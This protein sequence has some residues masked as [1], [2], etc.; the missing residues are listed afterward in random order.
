[1]LVLLS[2]LRSS[3]FFLVVTLAPLPFSSLSFH[4]TLLESLW[5]QRVPVVKTS[6]NKQRASRHKQIAS[7]VGQIMKPFG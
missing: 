1:M 6:L 4:K 3:I 7:Q 2:F 5:F